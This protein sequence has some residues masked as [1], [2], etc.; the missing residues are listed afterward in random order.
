VQRGMTVRRRLTRVVVSVG[1]LVAV[2]TFAPIAGAAV[3]PIVPP[4][5]G[6]GNEYVESLPGPGGNHPL[7][8]A[9]GPSPSK[10]QA[11]SPG[12]SQGLAIAPSA[13]QTLAKSGRAGRIVRDLAPQPRARA[14]LSAPTAK[15]TSP[16]SSIGS[17][18]GGTGRSGLGIG[19]P[20][21]LGV[22]TVAAIAFALRS[23]L[24]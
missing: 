2:L 5:N 16:A 23:R 17:L 13:A 6:A 1:C 4:A 15:A 24:G 19:L 14:A 3:T 7:S 9:S 22:A 21:I 12:S 10:T 20:I 8:A 18:I 11:S